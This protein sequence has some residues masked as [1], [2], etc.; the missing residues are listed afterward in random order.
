MAARK[1]VELS[2]LVA[3]TLA[4]PLLPVLVFAAARPGGIRWAAQSLFETLACLALPAAVLVWHLA[5]SLLRVLYGPGYDGAADALRVLTGQ[6]ALIPFSL[7]VSGV[8]LTTGRVAQAY[9]NA[10]LAT[11]VNCVLNFLLIPRMGAAGAAVAAVAAEASMLL[12]GC[13]YLYR[14]IGNVIV[15][16]T[17]T[18]ILSCNAALFVVLE[19]PLLGNAWSDALLG[20]LI[21]AALVL[22]ANV[23]P[24][25]ELAAVFGRPAEG[26]S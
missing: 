14:S 6:L 15:L 23:I 26:H 4:T 21:Y 24:R 13:W 3:S 2:A 20:T 11:L 19:H 8:L 7:V 9:W 10:P 1:L 5:P 25:A 17:W 16:R 12:V 22:G 18:K